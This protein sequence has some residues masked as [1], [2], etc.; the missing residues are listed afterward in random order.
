MFLKERLKTYREMAGLTQKQLAETIHTTTQNISQY[1]RGVRNPKFETVSKISEA[2]KISPNYFYD[3]SVDETE[4][5]GE[6]LKDQGEIATVALIK[7][8]YPSFVEES[9]FDGFKYTITFPNTNETIV[10]YLEEFL[11]IHDELLKMIPP[12]ILE[13]KKTSKKRIAAR[14]REQIN[15]FKMI[16]QQYIQGNENVTLDELLTEQLPKRK[17]QYDQ[18][19]EEDMKSIIFEVFANK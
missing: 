9:T 19:P 15:S 18:L 4:A 3:E 8:I 7:E 6:Y 2:L 12:M 17:H 10:F 14:K 16:I 5:V 11:H 13:I 1:E